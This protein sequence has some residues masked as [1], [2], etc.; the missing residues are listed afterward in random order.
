MKVERLYKGIAYIRGGIALNELNWNCV[1]QTE[2]QEQNEVFIE[3][4]NNKLTIYTDDKM[5]K[6]FGNYIYR[7]EFDVYLSNDVEKSELFVIVDEIDRVDFFDY[8]DLGFLRNNNFYVS[9]EAIL[10]ETDEKI[11]FVKEMFTDYKNFPN[12]VDDFLD[13][14]P[15]E[16]PIYDYLKK[17]SNKVIFRMTLKL[18]G[19]NMVREINV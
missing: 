17:E 6:I 7:D 4:E 5:D 18:N 10:K 3:S 2:E 12:T 14:F 15:H 9:L 19:R 11:V 13:L 8:R 16:S 1:L